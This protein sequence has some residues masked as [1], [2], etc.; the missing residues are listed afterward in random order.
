[1]AHGSSRSTSAECSSTLPG[2]ARPHPPMA[3][4]ARAAAGA[5]THSRHPS[6]PTPRSC[7]CRRPASLAKRRRPLTAAPPRLPSRSVPGT[8]KVEDTAVD[9]KE[10]YASADIVV[11]G[12]PSKGFQIA[13]SSLKAGVVAVNI[14]QRRSV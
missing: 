12:V 6:P 1:M 3:T 9:Q 13:A 11:S 2:G 7:P 10:A 14:S 5:A 8:I 4:R